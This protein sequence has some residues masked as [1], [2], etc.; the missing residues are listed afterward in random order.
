M[1][2]QPQRALRSALS[3]NPFQLASRE[4]LSEAGNLPNLSDFESMR[5]RPSRQIR[6]IDSSRTLRDLWALVGLGPW[7]GTED[8][9]VVA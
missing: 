9:I 4:R 5:P 6:R 1:R 8:E 3:A 2:F 7:N